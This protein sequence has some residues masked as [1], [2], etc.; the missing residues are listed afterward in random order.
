MYKTYVDTWFGELWQFLEPAINDTRSQ[1]GLD[2]C[3]S[4]TDLFDRHRRLYAV[5]PQAFDAPVSRGAREHPT[6]RLPRPEC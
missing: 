3:D 6:P 1:F 4:W 2:P 5:V